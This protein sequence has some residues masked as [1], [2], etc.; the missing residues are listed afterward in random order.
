MQIYARQKGIILSEY[1]KV[2]KISHLNAPHPRFRV[3]MHL[4]TWQGFSLSCVPFSWKNAPVH[5]ICRF[6]APCR[7]RGGQRPS[8]RKVI[9]CSISHEEYS[10]RIIQKW[11]IHIRD[12][13]HHLNHR[14]KLHSALNSGKDIYHTV[15]TL[16]GTHIGQET[17]DLDPH[18]ETF[19][20]VTPSSVIRILTS[21][22]SLRRASSLGIMSIIFL[23]L[24][25]PSSPLLYTASTYQDV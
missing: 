5:P 4:R 25:S 8:F 11:N 14:S 16:H 22:Y 21:H 17:T 3:G 20:R 13:P 10:L 2:A 19:L 18:K 12:I 24:L 15:V 6:S 7:L 23:G 9:V 1:S